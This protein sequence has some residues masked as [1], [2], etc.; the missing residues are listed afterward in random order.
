M[1]LKIQKSLTLS[2]SPLKHK[3]SV[4]EYVEV[5]GMTFIHISKRA[6]AMVGLLNITRV[7][8]HGK[9][10]LTNTDVIE[11]LQEARDEA[12]TAEVNK[13]V[14]PEDKDI[15][16]LDCFGEDPDA[17]ASPGARRVTRQ[18][19]SLI[20]QVVKINAPEIGPIATVEVNV[21]CTNKASRLFVELTDQLIEYLH[22]A[23]HHQVVNPI[24]KRVR[25]HGKAT[26]TVEKDEAQV[27]IVDKL[28]T[29]KCEASP[30]LPSPQ[31]KFVQGAA[32]WALKTTRVRNAAGDNTLRSY[33]SASVAG[34][35]HS[36]SHSN[37]HQNMSQML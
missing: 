30:M 36:R 32:T 33:F 14:K 35:E 6:P 25:L 9:R 11:Q 19:M 24:Q 31:F 3:V 29:P 28:D 26:R 2:G 1:P 20:P 15:V 13:H 17:S 10:T 37:P 8:G 21:L 16:A 27:A 22:T 12:F 4:T 34:G 23:I 5:E 18:V 7:D